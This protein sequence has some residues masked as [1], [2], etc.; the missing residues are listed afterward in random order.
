MPLGTLRRFVLALVI[1]CA[2]AA[3]AC[4]GGGILRQQYEYEEEIYLRLDGSATVFVNASVP[5][6]VAL[7][8]AELNVDSRARMDRE[9]I[10]AFF[11]AAGVRVST[12]TFS[13]RDGRRFVHA[14]LEV[15][16]VRQLQR[17]APLSWSTY[18]FEREGDIL[19]YRQVVGKAAAKP[20]HDVGWTGG[21]RVRFKMHLPSEI[22]YNNSPKPLQRGN[23]L[24]WEQP[25]QDRLAGMPL[26]IEANL[27]P[28][29]ILYTTLMLFAGTIVAAA[30]T[31]AIVIWWVV[32]KGRAQ[33]AAE[34]RPA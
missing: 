21:E 15:D 20:V 11:S 32:R 6:L 17:V 9:R 26:E 34:S 18:R 2:V 19:A 8:G 13:R 31:F 30:L 5:S 24:E 3:A 7:R 27:E 23:I 12:P 4:G 22:P 33:E 28:E 10:R 1:A 25:L 16:N 29:S 14:K